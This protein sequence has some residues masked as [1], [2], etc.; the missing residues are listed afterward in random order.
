MYDDWPPRERVVWLTEMAKHGARCEIYQN[1][2]LVSVIDGDGDLSQAMI[3]NRD[4]AASVLA[5]L[6]EWSNAPKH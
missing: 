3:D 5:D 4:A 6:M 1:G 2:V